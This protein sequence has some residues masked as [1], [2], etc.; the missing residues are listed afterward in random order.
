MFDLKANEIRLQAD[1]KRKLRIE[2]EVELISDLISTQIVNSMNDGLTRIYFTPDY[3][4]YL[5][6]SV[7]LVF[8][9]IQQNGFLVTKGSGDNK[10]ISW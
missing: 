5:L 9:K 10:W 8:D 2:R 4:E 1:E 6:E 3:N 7:G